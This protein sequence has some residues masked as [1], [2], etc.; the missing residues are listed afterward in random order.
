MFDF[1]I[2]SG[3]VYI[4]EDIHITDLTWSFSIICSMPVDIYTPL[5]QYHTLTLQVSC[6]L[7]CK[8]KV[9]CILY[10]LVQYSTSVL[11]LALI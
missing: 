3:D 8:K 4:R 7:P 5:I 6:I 10:T 11:G 1:T 2:G 9:S